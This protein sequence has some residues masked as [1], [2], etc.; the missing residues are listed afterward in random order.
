MEGG[1]YEREEVLD[2]GGGE[3]A[4]DEEKNLARGEGGGRLVSPKP[5]W[6]VIAPV[7]NVVVDM[8][9]DNGSEE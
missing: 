8:A 4:V 2:N 5:R 7:P 1:V 6:V 3:T 9:S